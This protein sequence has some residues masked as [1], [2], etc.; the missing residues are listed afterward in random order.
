M[1]EKIVALVREEMDFLGKAELH[2]LTA[3]GCR[4]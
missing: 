3:A 2:A 4:A 1:P